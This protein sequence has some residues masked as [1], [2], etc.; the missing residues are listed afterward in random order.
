MAVAV[1]AG[2]GADL[3]SPSLLYPGLV[4]LF[5]DFALAE[6]QGGVDQGLGHPWAVPASVNLDHAL[7]AILSAQLIDLVV[8]HQLVSEGS[9]R[10]LEVFVFGIGIVPVPGQVVGRVTA[11]TDAAQRGHGVLAGLWRGGMPITN[12]GMV[13]G[14]S[15][16]SVPLTTRVASYPQIDVLVSGSFPGEAW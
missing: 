3:V 10:Q 11:L 1:R 4:C 9:G 13:V 6:I 15:G 7:V 2:L 12:E 16:S 14:S 8:Q 5:V